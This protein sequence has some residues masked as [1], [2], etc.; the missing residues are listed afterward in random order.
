MAIVTNPFQLARQK[1]L[2]LKE[3]VRY[4]DIIRLGGANARDLQVPV[5]PTSSVTPTNTNTPTNEP[6]FTPTPTNTITPTVTPTPS[7]TSSVTPTP[8]IT[9]SVTLTPT[10]TVTRTPAITP[11]V[12][13]TATPTVTPTYTITPTNTITS[14]VTPTKT[15]TSTP[16]ITPTITQSVTPTLTRT[17]T[18]TVTP[19]ETNPLPPF[20]TLTNLRENSLSQQ[21]E[22]RIIYLQGY[23]TQGDGGGGNFIFDSTSLS[24]DDGGAVIKP[25]NINSNNPGRWIRQFSGNAS[26]EM[27]GAKGDGRTNDQPAI[28]RAI[29]YAELN[30]PYKLLFDCKT[31]VLTSYPMVQND[32]LGTPIM[33]EKYWQDGFWKNY[34]KLDHLMVGFYPNPDN[35]SP[36]CLNDTVSANIELIGTRDGSRVT[37]LS[38]DCS[39][40]F[41][42]P[43]L[44]LFPYA[45]DYRNVYSLNC[46]H[47]IGF[48]RNLSAV[49]MKD[50]DLIPFALSTFPPYP[51][52]GITTDAA[53]PYGGIVKRGNMSTTQGFGPNLYSAEETRTPFRTEIMYLS[54]VRFINC[55]RSLTTGEGASLPHTGIKKMQ[56]YKCEFLHPN[57][58][59]NSVTH[60]GQDT[61]FEPGASLLLFDSITAEGISNT[62]YQFDSNYQHMLRGEDGFLT[63]QGVSAVLTN[64]NF[65]RYTIETIIAGYTQS[66]LRA[67]RLTIPRIGEQVTVSFDIGFWRENYIPDQTRGFYTW[68]HTITGQ[69]LPAG[70]IAWVTLNGQGGGGGGNYGGNYIIN[71]YIAE[72]IG[73]NNTLSA[74]MTRLSGG[75]TNTGNDYVQSLN[76]ELNVR[77]GDT[78]NGAFV[79]P[80]IKNDTNWVPSYTQIVDCQFNRGA[81]YVNPL[82]QDQHTNCIISHD[83]ACNMVGTGNY[84]ISGCLFDQCK[85][86]IVEEINFGYFDSK[87][88]IEKNT[89]NFIALTAVSGIQT[90]Y[91]MPDLLNS[92][93]NNT[94]FRNNSA[95]GPF[96]LDGNPIN[97]LPE[98]FHQIYYNSS[99]TWPFDYPPYIDQIH[100]PY[101]QHLFTTQS[102]NSFYIDNTITIYAPLCADI[103]RYYN[104]WGCNTWKKPIDVDTT[105]QTNNCDP[106]DAYYATFYNTITGNI[107]KPIFLSLTDLRIGSQSQQVNGRV[108]YLQGYYAPGDNG[109]GN[110]IF[111]SAS[112]SVDDG[113]A[114]VR[115]NNINSN[116]PGRWIRQF[117]GY[118]NVEMWGAK[119]NRAD[120]N[121]ASA[122]QKAIDYCSDHGPVNLKLSAKTYNLSSYNNTRIGNGTGSGGNVYRFLKTLLAVGWYPSNKGY[123]EDTRINLNLQGMGSEMTVLC[124]FTPFGGNDVGQST[125]IN[126][127]EQVNSVKIHDLKIIR[128][129]PNYSETY[130]VL[131]S[132]REGITVSSNSPFVPPPLKDLNTQLISITGCTFDNCHRV[133]TVS[134]DAIPKGIKKLEFS[135]N[136]LLHPFG[137]DSGDWRGGSQMTYWSGEVESSEVIGNYCEGNTGPMPPNCANQLPIDGFLFY[138]GLNCLVKDN[139]ISKV[140]VEGL[141]LNTG[142]YNVSIG[143]GWSTNSVP[144]SV[145]PIGKQV[146]VKIETNY[147]T[148]TFVKYLSANKIWP[149]EI[150]QHVS[151]RTS[152]PLPENNAASS[153]F[154]TI[155]SILT[156]S[157]YPFTL[158]MTRVSSIPGDSDKFANW[159]ELYGSND[160][161][162]PTNPFKKTLSS[163]TTWFS[164]GYIQNI[165]TMYS[166]AS[167]I[168]NTFA[169]GVVSGSSM[170]PSHLGHRPCIRTDSGY[171]LISANKF[172]N[173]VYI[174]SLYDVYRSADIIDNDFYIYG[175]NPP[176][177]GDKFQRSLY[178]STSGGIVKNNRFWF[179]VDGN[180]TLTNTISTWWPDAYAIREYGAIALNYGEAALLGRNQKFI[181]NTLYLTNSLCARAI[182]PY[183]WRSPDI[184]G[185]NGF[186]DT[187]G[188]TVSG[189]VLRPITP[190]VVNTITDLRNYL[191]YTD[192]LLVNAAGRNYIYDRYSL[193]SDD[194]ALVIKP[195]NLSPSLSGRWIRQ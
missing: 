6:I 181:D 177:V 7:I 112:L 118:A 15:A 46:S 158:Y 41:T 105:Q 89:F 103:F 135:Y 108:I 182:T 83:P 9:S 106:S 114:I 61:L 184:Y 51:I 142:S 44:N 34:A 121:D 8:S 12:T 18:P 30:T 143:E 120:F 70:K 76:K 122:I 4:E 37:T 127:C 147:S 191:K 72:S 27:W 187:L 92:C 185:N 173:G 98:R 57:E 33:P 180:E 168:N 119:G 78:F 179:W 194:G 88:E 43:P 129:D 172:Y 10:N 170:Y 152:D 193:A 73:M 80:Y 50:F 58:L 66:G 154:Y 13:K 84:Y 19:T 99:D 164:G 54:G 16:A 107:I 1:R 65:N 20:I 146:F 97:Y 87:G 38:A 195:S 47:I 77:T 86:P 104:L 169:F 69:I 52:Y 109:G 32:P 25:N 148:E 113:G 49:K 117:N 55:S 167:A 82:L 128:R 62:V 100:P 29:R 14:S 161:N 75:L 63:S 111:N 91:Y 139:Y 155:D 141:Y 85:N 140:G 60:A 31:Y 123:N 24:V 64:C 48:C 150:V 163:P 134:R 186:V 188:F 176:V 126:I 124:T 22:G 133:L 21:V 59:L 101:L 137:S 116:S 53:T 90:A 156:G 166:R 2:R 159:V 28:Q 36:S 68:L 160:P 149:G 5:T 130:G 17:S 40:C 178:Y 96:D 79:Y 35:N 56:V 3:A 42:T 136:T 125:V 95:F 23:Y 192:F 189:N 174:S 115:P 138:T 153:G 39:F 93:F 183:I 74:V 11:S 102:Y 145:P 157:S 81:S 94:M 144:L 45:Y 131:A 190:V 175:E 26:V 71:Q 151:G 132:T 162:D 67:E 165:N 110:F 171:S